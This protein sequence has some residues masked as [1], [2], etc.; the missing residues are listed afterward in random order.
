MDPETVNGG[1]ENL[2]VGEAGENELSALLSVDF[3]DI[4][5]DGDS[6][7]TGE[8]APAVVEQPA[9]A[10]TTPVPEPAPAAVAQPVVAPAPAAVAPAPVAAT[11]PVVATPQP[12]APV[13]TPQAQPVVAPEPAPAVQDPTVLARENYQRFRSEAETALANAHYALQPEVLERFAQND[14]SDIPKMMA[15][16]YMDAYTA[17]IAHVNTHFPSMLEST[18]QVKSVEA[19]HEESFF[20]AWPQLNLKDHGED[21]KRYGTVYRQMNPTATP[22]EFIRDVGA[23]VIVAKRIPYNQAAPIAPSNGNGIPPAPIAP[24][25][26]AVSPRPF[27]PAS[28]RSGGSPPTPAAKA[29]N[30]FEQLSEDVDE[31]DVD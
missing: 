15:K 23:Q 20:A 9:A 10:T 6:Q 3:E 18:S 2:A 12:V 8:A 21:I 17:A 29:K 24:A 4:D 13:V 1:E 11:P 26:A 16:V 14:F 31:L 28:G 5:K 19:K 25:P 30:P 22:E 27:T 7:G